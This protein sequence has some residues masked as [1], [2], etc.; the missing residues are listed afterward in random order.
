[1]K[2]IFSMPFF[3]WNRT[4]TESIISDRFWILWLKAL[5]LTGATLIVWLASS[6][7][8]DYSKKKLKAFKVCL[9]HGNTGQLLTSSEGSK[10]NRALAVE[11]A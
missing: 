10:D 5:P 6:R 2:T 4:G 8:E 11:I 9:K 7:R 3:D 1:M